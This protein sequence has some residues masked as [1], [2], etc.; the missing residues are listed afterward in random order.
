MVGG[1]FVCMNVCVCLCVCLYLYVC[2]CVSVCLCV[3][4]VV[5]VVLGWWSGG[6]GVVSS[7]F[8][9]ILFQDFEIER[10]FQ[11]KFR[12][13]VSLSYTKFHEII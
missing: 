3:M 1:L 12:K 2:V 10:S 11:R 9:T 13:E 8:V 6:G 5:V 4:V 7:F